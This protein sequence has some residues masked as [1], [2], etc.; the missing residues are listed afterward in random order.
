MLKCCAA[1]AFLNAWRLLFYLVYCC[2]STINKAF[3]ASLWRCVW[4]FLVCCLEVCYIMFIMWLLHV[5]FALVF[6]GVHPPLTRLGT[7]T[8]LSPRFFIFLFWFFVFGFMYLRISACWMV[9]VS[10]WFMY[11]YAVQWTKCHNLTKKA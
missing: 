11:C 3:E 1:C 8:D 7:R 5:V 2:Q 4:L 6:D 9:I 10:H